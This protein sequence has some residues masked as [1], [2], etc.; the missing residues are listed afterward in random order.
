MPTNGPWAYSTSS[1]TEAEKKTFKEHTGGKSS[2]LANKNL[3]QSAQ[4]AVEHS[5][6]RLREIERYVTCILTIS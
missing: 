3:D 1:I 2:N 4:V 6:S 5:E